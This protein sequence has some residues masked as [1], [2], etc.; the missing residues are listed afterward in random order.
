MHHWILFSPLNGITPISL[1]VWC[2]RSTLVEIYA[3]TGHLFSC[4]F[5][6]SQC[7]VYVA[8]WLR[9]SRVTLASWCRRCIFSRALHYD[10][11]PISCGCWANSVTSSCHSSVSSSCTDLPVTDS[12]SQILSFYVRH[13][14]P[15]RSSYI[16]RSGTVL[17]CGGTAAPKIQLLPQ[18]L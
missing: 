9:I 8:V 11:L 13:G 16:Q 14:L 4:W 3:T 10:C 7:F 18:I 17:R 1:F 15:R 2:W 5:E 12:P 6:S